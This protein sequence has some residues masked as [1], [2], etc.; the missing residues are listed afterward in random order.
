[1][2][3]P[4]VNERGPRRSGVAHLSALGFAFLF[5]GCFQYTATDVGSVSPG[6]DVRIRITAAQFDEMEE[7]IP[8]HDRVLEGEVI[9]AHGDS[10]LVE[11]PVTVTSDGLRVNSLKQRFSLP[12]TGIVEVE[13][14]TLDKRRTYTVSAAVALVAGIFLYQQLND[15]AATGPGT[16]N[17]PPPEDRI[18]IF[19]L[20]LRIP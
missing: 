13:G 7:H 11:V 5:S 4:C 1:M 10:L 9:E 8:G 3:Q 14:R 12:A 6:E 15:D 19:S 20:P 2:Q 17:P 16:P 18:T